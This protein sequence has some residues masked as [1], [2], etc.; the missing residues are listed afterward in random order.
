MENW[1]T[2]LTPGAQCLGTYT[3]EFSAVPYTGSWLDSGAYRIAM[4]FA[5]PMPVFQTSVHTGD[6][7]DVD[8]WLEIEGD[9]VVVSAL[10]RSELRKDGVREGVILRIYNPAETTQ[11]LTIKP[12]FNVASVYQTDLDERPIAELPVSA[13]DKA[14]CG[15]CCFVDRVEPKKIA[16]YLIEP[17][18]KDLRARYAAE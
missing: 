10:K 16:T 17:E 7:A 13:A 18:P 4:D 8:S 5:A 6:R 3:F 9:H 1:G 15:S 11:D 14:E 2:F 12:R